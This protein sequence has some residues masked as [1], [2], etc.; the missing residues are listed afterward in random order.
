MN[1]EQKELR[2]KLFNVIN[3]LEQEKLQEELKQNINNR[4]NAISWWNNL[5]IIDKSLLAQKHAD[6]LDGN[7][8]VSLN[9]S[10]IE[11]IYL[12]SYI[13]EKMARMN[14][15]YSKKD[16]TLIIIPKYYFNGSCSLITMIKSAN[17]I[18]DIFVHLMPNTNVNDIYCSEIYH[19]M[20]YK[21][22]WRFS[23]NCEEC[24]IGVDQYESSMLD[25]IS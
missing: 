18:K 22:N 10:S 8:Y 16:K 7:G 15:F 20:R 21:N 14:I 17:E 12:E 11:M 9:D 25:I 2:K 1:D 6:M 5:P 23:V 24:P 3:E 19:S 4:I 13:K